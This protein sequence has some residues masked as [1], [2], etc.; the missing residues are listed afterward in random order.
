MFDAAASLV[1]VPGNINLWRTRCAPS[2]LKEFAMVAEELPRVGCRG[3]VPFAPLTV[4]M[5]PLAVLHQVATAP[6]PSPSH[7]VWF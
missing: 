6:P 5:V 7:S 4:S 3:P 1:K 2:A